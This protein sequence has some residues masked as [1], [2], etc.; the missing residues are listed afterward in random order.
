MPPAS[1]APGAQ[2]VVHVSA[3]LPRPFAEVALDE[4]EL[5]ACFLLSSGWW[6]LAATPA[7]LPDSS[8]VGTALGRLSTDLL[9]SPPLDTL[10]MVVAQG[11]VSFPTAV[12]FGRTVLVLVPAAGPTADE[13]VSQAAATALLAARVR[14]ARPQPEVSEPLL[15]TAEALALA[16]SFSLAALPPALRPVHDWMERRDA[17]PALES[18]IG[19]ALDA[20]TPWKTRRALVSRI[21]QPD[22]ASPALAHAAAFLVEAFGD[23][24]GARGDP[25]ALL[26]AWRKGGDRFPPVPHAL[27]RALAKPAEAGMSRD[28]E[29]GER[30]AL[31]MET[32]E[33]SVE[34]GEG[35]E[36]PP[37]GAVPAAL[38]LTAAALARANGSAATCRWI[39]DGVPADLRTGCRREG[40][41][42]GILYARPRADGSSE[43]LARSPTGAEGVLLRWPGW[44]LFPQLDAA[45]GQIVFADA[46]GVWRV[47]LDGASPPVA[48]LTGSFRHLAISPAGDALAAVRWPSGKVVIA[49][50]SGVT[51][52]PVD[53]RGGIAWLA[54]DVL[55]ASDGKGLALAATSG[56]VR[57]VDASVPCTHSLG[58]RSGVALIA[59]TR[60][61]EPAL[62]ALAVEEKQAR[63]LL[64][65]TDGAL[66]LAARPDGAVFFCTAEGLW[67]WGGG[68]SAERI[69][70]GFTPGPG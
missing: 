57:R 12:A 14:A 28:P 18:F 42:A 7:A 11:E 54:P 17:F 30:A 9:G 45:H 66:G 51:E 35:P 15:S 41:A 10:T 59:T 33:R 8:T 68:E 58:A 67:R 24:A 13:S 4:P 44:V 62:L 65:L 34:S 2:V 36:Q 31:A 46:R 1:Q 23:A 19:E 37:A 56:E 70:V 52:L 69:G 48:A 32:L 60:P 20:S 53:G 39:N 21:G 40:E 49:N 6:T 26:R 55:I 25:M 64:R 63:T 50:G 61:C 29:P 16:G 38:R 43:I 27:K 22:G 3:W 5:A 47:P